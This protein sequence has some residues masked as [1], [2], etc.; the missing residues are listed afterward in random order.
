LLELKIKDG[1]HEP[2]GTGDLQKH[3]KARKK[4]PHL[5]LWEEAAILIHFSHFI[6]LKL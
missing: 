4:I 1:S 6:L 5:S 3:E 2:K